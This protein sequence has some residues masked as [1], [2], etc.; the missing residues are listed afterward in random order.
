MSKRL[1][2]L[3]SNVLHP[4][5][6]LVCSTALYSSFVRQPKAYALLDT[7][8]LVAGIIPALTYVEV[9]KQRGAVASRHLTKRE[10]RPVALAL[11]LA[12]FV[13][14]LVVYRLINAPE[15]LIVELL[16]LLIGGIPI[17]LIT[18]VWKISFHAAVAAACAALFL[19]ISP[20]VTLC[21]MALALLVGLA[22]IPIDHH[23]PAQVVAG[24]AYGF[25]VTAAL[26]ALFA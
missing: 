17:S 23:T 2:Y 15:Q 5:I 20:L 12:G 8:I 3:L 11:A 22:R 10:E 13:G 9:L 16:I 19:T 18:L 25:L 1:A 21:L 24:W 7:L 6:F 14:S 26:S 4:A